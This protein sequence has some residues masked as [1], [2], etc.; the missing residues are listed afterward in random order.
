MCM[1][2]FCVYNLLTRGSSESFTNYGKEGQNIKNK[3]EEGSQTTPLSRGPE[4]LLPGGR[5]PLRRPGPGDR[6]CRGSPPREGFSGTRS[7]PPV[8][9]VPRTGVSWKMFEEGSELL[10]R[11][12]VW[13][14]GQ[15]KWVD[16]DERDAVGTGVSSD[17]RDP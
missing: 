10:V 15:G 7:R 17:R 14:E 1:H 9:P 5:L 12:R 13:V 3:T 2:I 11:G 16:T 4:T 6:R 8:T